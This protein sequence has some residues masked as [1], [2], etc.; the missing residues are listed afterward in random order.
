MPHRYIAL[1]PLLAYHAMLCDRAAELPSAPPAELAAWA[2]AMHCVLSLLTEPLQ[3][4]VKGVVMGSCV[5][6]PA[7]SFE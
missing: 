1:S 3:S 4:R 5:G 2:A 6:G 7:S